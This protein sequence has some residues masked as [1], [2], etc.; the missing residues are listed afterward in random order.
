MADTPAPIDVIGRELPY[1]Q[2]AELA[3]IGSA[4]TNPHSVAESAEI[5]KPSDFYFP[6]NREIYSAII[7]L[8]NENLAIDFITVSNRLSQNDKL[9]AVGGIT[10]LRNAAT[11]VP[12]TRH[13]T[14]YSSII[15]DKAT[16]RALIQRANAI[17]DMAYSES[18][19]V[20]RVVAQAEQLIFDVS[21]S[22]ERGDILPVSEI[23]LGSYR[24]LVEN[25]VNQGGITGLSTGFDELNRRTG[26]FHNGELILIAGRPGMG[27][28]SFAVNIAEYV[29]ITEKKTVAIFNLEM[30]REQI[31]NRIICS[32]ALVDS[33]KIRTG[34]ITG[35]DWEKIG[36]IV[37][38]VSAA[39][40]YIDDTASI[41]VSEIR[42]KCRRLK[43]TKNLSMIVIDYLQLMQSSGRSEN[44]Q[45]E[46][47]EI[48]RS[49]KIL[50]KELEVPVVAL[51]QLSRASESRSD[52]RPVLSDLR[53]S[54]AIEQDA[55]IVMFLYR[56]D[57]YKED[58]D[59][60]NIAECRI[61]KNRSGETGTFKLGWNG[62]YTKFSNL[63]FAVKEE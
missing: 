6:Q 22:R 18:D 48:S 24:E 51:S 17:S 16:L 39:P 10:Y 61:A 59:E 53:E 43:Q 3:V 14:Y 52:K 50:A 44:R 37:D 13:V 8:F 32:Q 49:L 55:D 58:T 20:E 11:N 27:K 47:S 21:S 35:E 63:E 46:I 41:T 56:D 9:E 62:K 5:V 34:D 15:K 26:G 40:L 2:D 31:V 23:F 25:S 28:S 42:A 38:K 45:Q 7:E 30:P 1:S 57:Y 36:S 54:G 33:N 29:S 19:K 60:K 12:T 4:L